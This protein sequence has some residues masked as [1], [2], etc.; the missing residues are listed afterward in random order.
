MVKK[1]QVSVVMGSDRDADVMHEATRVLDEFRVPWEVH[2]ISAHRSPDRCRAFAR[3]ASGRGIKVVIAGA[4]KAAHL[5][6]VI[7]SHT[8]LPVIGVPLDAGMNG[9]DALLATVQMPWGV[10]VASMAVGGT[11]AANAALY[12]VEILALS[13]RALARNLAAFR[14][15]QT[16]EVAAKSKSVSR[17][18]KG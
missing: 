12:A 18:L 10:P 17:R 15:R 14:K 6:G 16:A 13:D 2:V 8:T 5:A 9:M 1:P 3:G 4:G 7:A 11:G